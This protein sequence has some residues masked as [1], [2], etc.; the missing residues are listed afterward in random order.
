MIRFESLTV[1]ALKLKHLEDLCKDYG[2]VAIYLGA[3]PEQPN[4]F[5]LDVEHFFE[6]GKPRLGCRNTAVMLSETRFG[7]QFHVIGDRSRHFS[8]FECGHGA[9]DLSNT[10]G[11]C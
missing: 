8:R 7:R 6:T 1:R 9:P 4:G 2:Q 5:V 11:C 3:D 10:G